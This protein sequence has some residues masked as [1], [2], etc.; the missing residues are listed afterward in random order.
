[1]KI[2]SRYKAQEGTYLSVVPDSSSYHYLASFLSKVSSLS[3]GRLAVPADMHCTVMFA[4]TSI[5]TAE[6]QLAIL[7]KAGSFKAVSKQLT[8]WHGGDGDS[9]IVLELDCPEL[10]EFHGWLRSEFGMEPTF[11]DYKP[12]ITLVS[13]MPACPTGSYP[14]KPVELTLSGLRIEDTK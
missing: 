6:Q 7:Q 2:E 14:I 9:Y 12:H 5:L 3:N 11:D 10:Q 8:C 1:M 4:P 13:S